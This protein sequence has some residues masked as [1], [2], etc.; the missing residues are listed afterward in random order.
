MFEKL[1]NDFDKL[2]RD[3]NLI[4]NQGVII[5]GSFVEIPRSLDEEGRTEI[6]RLQDTHENRCEKQADKEICDDERGTARL[7]SDQV[8]D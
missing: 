7:G 3:N 8:A 2:L 1:F 5:D 6:L 4:L